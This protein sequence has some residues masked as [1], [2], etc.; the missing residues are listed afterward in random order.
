VSRVTS[1]GWCL[2]RL[3]FVAHTDDQ[4][5]RMFGTGPDGRPRITYRIGAPVPRRAPHTLKAVQRAAVAAIA[6]SD[7]FWQI[8]TNLFA[9]YDLPLDRAALQAWRRQVFRH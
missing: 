9:C 7:V 5:G 8:D 2:Y 4:V 1:W 3:L 6:H